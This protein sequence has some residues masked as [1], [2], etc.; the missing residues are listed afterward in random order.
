V[1]VLQ[2]TTKAP[3]RLSVKG[4]TTPS[5]GDI[6]EVAQVRPRMG[7]VVRENESSV[8]IMYFKPSAIP[9]IAKDFVWWIDRRH[10]TVVSA[11]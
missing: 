10:I 1:V 5:V 9:G 2:P 4:N 7:I 11:A 8:G 6:V 3:W